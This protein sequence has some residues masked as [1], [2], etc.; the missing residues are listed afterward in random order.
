M[1]VT[2]GIGKPLT[3]LWLLAA[4]AALATAEAKAEQ[5]VGPFWGLPYPYGYA[6]PSAP[7]RQKRHPVCAGYAEENGSGPARKCGKGLSV[8]Y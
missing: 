7:W 3:M 5:I 4:A 1:R 2:S 6:Y 8:R